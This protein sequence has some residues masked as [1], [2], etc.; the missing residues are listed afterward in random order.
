VRVDR[1]EWYLLEA[2]LAR[3]EA[4]KAAPAVGMTIARAGGGE[5]GA[6]EYGRRR[7]RQQYTAEESQC[8]GKA[9]WAVKNASVPCCAC[10]W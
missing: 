10:T 7:R 9:T 2:H 6:G 5:G 4:I 3:E 1:G 8:R